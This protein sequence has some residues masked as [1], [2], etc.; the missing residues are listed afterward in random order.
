M[1]QCVL[2][3]IKTA[4][5]L[6]IAEVPSCFLIQ[7]TQTEAVFGLLQRGALPAQPQSGGLPQDAPHAVRLH[8]H[9]VTEES[10]GEGRPQRGD[11]AS[12]VVKIIEVLRGS[13][14]SNILMSSSH[15]PGMVVHH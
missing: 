1:L 10:L 6:V 13:N 5:D 11:S 7:I 3:H 2:R 15:S 12:E 9:G 8:R 14:Q 4:D